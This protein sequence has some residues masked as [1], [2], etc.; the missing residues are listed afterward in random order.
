MEIEIGDNGRGFDPAHAL[1]QPGHY[2]LRGL[3]ERARLLAGS[4]QILSRPGAGT[5]IRFAFPSAERGTE[6][7]HDDAAQAYSR[8]HRG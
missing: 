2:G 7:A 5:T 8:D 4:A 6:E 3:H 1:A